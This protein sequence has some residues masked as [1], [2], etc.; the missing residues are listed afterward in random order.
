MDVL[1]ILN[2]AT[3]AYSGFRVSFGMPVRREWDGMLIALRISGG[4]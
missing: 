3:S 4:R 2:T 1:L